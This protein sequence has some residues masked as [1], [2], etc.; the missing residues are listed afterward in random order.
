MA[1]TN[2]VYPASV[3]VGIGVTAHDNT[4]IATATFEGFSVG[5]LVNP[6][7]PPR[8]VDAAYSGGV[9][10]FGITTEANRSYQVL[11]KTQLTDANWTP[12]TT[13][14]GTGGV[15]PVTDPAAGTRF[16]RVVAQ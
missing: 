16:Y 3:L 2:Q 6:P 15:V 5:A 1:Q 7:A 13:V 9:F 12:L 10:S 4:Q 14:P 8:L 11:Y